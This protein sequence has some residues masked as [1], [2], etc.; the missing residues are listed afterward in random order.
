MKNRLIIKNG[1][2]IDPAR[3]IEETA[4]LI[5]EKGKIVASGTGL[6]SLNNDD[7][8]N[9]EVIDAQ[10]MIVAPGFIDMHCHLREPGFEDKET[11][12]TGCRAAAAGGFTTICC[13]PNTHPAADNTATLSYIK[14]TAARDSE[15]RVLPIASVTVNRA[16]KE[17]APMIELAGAGAVGFSDDGSPVADSWI[18]LRALEY[19]KPLGVPIINHCEDPALVANGVVNEGKT[20]VSLG[21]PG[22]PSI[23]EEVMIARDVK[24]A[25][26]TG[27]W[28]HIAHI[29]TAGGVDIIREAKKRGI[30]VTAEVT[31]HHLGLT[32]EAVA[33]YD[34]NAR[35]NPPL[36]TTEDVAALIAGLKNGTIDI[37]ATD[38][39]PHTVSDK[40]QE[41]GFAPPGI[42]GF[43]TAL[44]VV[45]KLVH[46]GHIKMS[47]MI[48][49]LTS[50]PSRLLAKTGLEL[51]T[52][53]AGSTADVTIIDPNR[54]W[55]VDGNAF[56]SKGKNTP[57]QGME[58]KGKVM[59][60]IAGGKIIFNGD[61]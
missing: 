13:M 46:D 49:M 60:T 6:A 16:G 44:G 19:S 15:I 25:E 48:A 1:L 22:N 50:S 32:E 23:S 24:L 8:E 43:E 42:S 2:I 53:R 31:P 61:K 30:K 21:L 59:F 10:G 28:V 12:K 14:E 55:T 35:V 58:L 11:I 20:S 5:I 27:G 41:F 54:T 33:G 26:Y 56:L 51:G 3:S 47:E 4:D 37:I 34:T 52:L 57:W 39:A 29:S 40:T 17:L 36:R 7:K 38:H 9:T 18:M 45:I